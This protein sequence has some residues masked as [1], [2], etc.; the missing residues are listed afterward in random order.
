LLAKKQKTSYSQQTPGQ[1][2]PFAKISDDYKTSL[3]AQVAQFIFGCNVPEIL[4][5]PHFISLVN[6]LRP[7]Y[8]LPT[9]EYLQEKL[10]N[11]LVDELKACQ[12]TEKDNP[13]T[14][15]MS[16]SNSE[17]LSFFVRSHLE[18]PKFVTVSEKTSDFAKQISDA[19]EKSVEIYGVKIVA[20]CVD[21][22]EVGNCLENE[23]KDSYY[24]HLDSDV[25]V[26]TCKSKLTSE[27]EKIVKNVEIGVIIESLVSDVYKVPGAFEYLGYDNK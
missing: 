7:G 5:S 1:F 16:G 26:Y 10:L 2:K 19:V 21:D 14:L 24:G 22:W 13:G 17:K 18:K 20:V 25:Q 12:E 9:K 15:L 8:V 6:C 11:E 27:Y 3:D 23:I 4:Q